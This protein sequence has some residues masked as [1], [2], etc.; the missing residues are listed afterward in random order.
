MPNTF[1]PRGAP[2]AAPNADYYKDWELTNRPAMLPFLAEYTNTQTGAKSGGMAMPSMVTSPANALWQLVGPAG[3]MWDIE[4]T[5]NADALREVNMATLGGEAFPAITR[6]ALARGAVP[7]FETYASKWAATP[8]EERSMLHPGMEEG[9]RRLYGHGEYFTSGPR[10]IEV[11]ERAK[12]LADSIR[13]YQAE[14]AK[15][16]AN[17]ALYG[18]LIKDARRA[19][20]L[21]AGDARA[22]DAFKHLGVEDKFSNALAKEGE[23]YV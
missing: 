21:Y 18:P 11:R 3:G 6:N 9:I 1:R 15:D 10:G 7:N 12:G 5:Q 19:I 17:E 8:A 2:N 14:I 13:S 20:E 22:N 16:P 4:N 23:L